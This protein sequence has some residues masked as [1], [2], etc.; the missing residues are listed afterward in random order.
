[1]IAFNQKTHPRE[2]LF[3][4]CEE[5][6]DRINRAGSDMVIMP[7]V[8][9]VHDTRDRQGRINGYILGVESGIPAG[10]FPKTDIW[11]DTGM[12]H[13]CG[14]IGPCNKGFVHFFSR[15]Y[16]NSLVLHDIPRSLELW[17]A[18]NVC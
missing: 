18:G 10:K 8:K 5:L 14:N 6:I 17:E 13:V 4:R 9:Q 16:N 12:K 2:Y 7:L 11:I 15:P 3:Q 1:M